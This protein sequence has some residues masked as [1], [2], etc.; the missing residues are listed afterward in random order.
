MYMY[1]VRVYVCSFLTSP[2]DTVSAC[3]GGGPSD[4]E[5]LVYHPSLILSFCALSSDLHFVTIETC[6]SMHVHV[7]VHAVG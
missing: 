2:V 5:C 1:N 4:R 6:A 7:Y 3:G